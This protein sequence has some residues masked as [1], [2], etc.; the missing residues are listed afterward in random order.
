MGAA[1]VG[2]GRWLGVPHGH[3]KHLV[4]VRLRERK[5]KGGWG[6]LEVR[7]PR[8]FIPLL[9][10]AAKPRATKAS[11]RSIGAGGEIAKC[12]APDCREA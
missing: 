9:A 2:R 1:T 4:F 11:A 10:A 8:C 3:Y 6:Q 7:L 5:R 12:R